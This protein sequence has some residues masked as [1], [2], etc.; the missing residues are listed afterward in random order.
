MTQSSADVRLWIDGRGKPGQSGWLLLL[1]WAQKG[2][3]A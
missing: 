3:G 1:L 2:G